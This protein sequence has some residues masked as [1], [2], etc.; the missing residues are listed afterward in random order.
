MPTTTIGTYWNTDDNTTTDN[1]PT[2]A[3]RQKKQYCNTV[4]RYFRIK[5]YNVTNKY[6]S[7]CVEFDWR[8]RGYAS[9][10]RSGS[11]IDRARDEASA[12]EKF[13]QNIINRWIEMNDSMV[14]CSRQYYRRFQRPRE[15]KYKINRCRSISWL[16][17]GQQSRR[18]AIRQKLATGIDNL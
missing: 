17:V 14:K 7:S 18:A 10:S 4:N 15:Y 6:N 8:W 5:K 1:F 3:N 2:P 9:H 13:K 12:P 16:V 11:E